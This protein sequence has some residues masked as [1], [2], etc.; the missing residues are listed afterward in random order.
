[1]PRNDVLDL[2][3]QKAEEHPAIQRWAETSR[4]KLAGNILTALRD[5][6]ALEGTQKIYLVR[7]SLPLSTAEHLLRIL[8]VE[9]CRGAK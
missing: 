4:V 2:L 5:F 7:P 8:T 1:M 6:G 9:G 3:D